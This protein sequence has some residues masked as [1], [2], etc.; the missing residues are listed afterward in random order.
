M[1]IETNIERRPRRK[2]PPEVRRQQLIDAAME[3]IAESGI[4][5]ATAAAVTSRAGLS[6]GIVSLHFDGMKG[7]LTETLRSLAE[8]MRDVWADAYADVDVD[9]ADRLRAII[10][11]VFNKTTCTPTKIAVWFAFFG[12]ARYRQIYRAIVD[13]FDKEREGAMADLCALIKTQGGYEG[14][15]PQSL[16]TAIEALADGLWLSLLLYPDWMEPEEAR[17]RIFEMIAAHFPNHFGASSQACE[18]S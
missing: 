1:N 18:Q 6:L 9:P 7:L 13:D 12:E 2:A 10:D 14:V 17:L 11:A 5:G 16:A 8:E 15:N 3:V 4:S